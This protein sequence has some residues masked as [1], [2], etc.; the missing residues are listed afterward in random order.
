[1]FR[2]L[3]NVDNKIKLALLLTLFM[4]VVLLS[5]FLERSNFS[6]IDESVESIY[7]DRLVPSAYIFHLTDHLYRRRLIL[8]AH[9]SGEAPNPPEV[10]K[11]RLWAHALAMDTLIND[12]ELTYL[13]G[14][15]E[16][17]LDDFKKELKAYTL[18]E[19][20]LLSAGNNFLQPGMTH[21]RFIR[22]FDSTLGSL[23]ALSQVQLT[24]GKQL[25]DDSHSIAA[26]SRLLTNF[27]MALIIIVALFVQ[28]LVIASR[29]VLPAKQRPNL[30]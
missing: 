21:D 28:V 9:F 18:F 6:S 3:G 5:N 7:A 27:E 4:V 29:P 16:A 2:L 12:F 23:T 14:N 19:Q 15:E 13:V 24:A 10:C 25:L 11:K 22:L 26:S 1:M 20:E 8:Q 30:N 17:I